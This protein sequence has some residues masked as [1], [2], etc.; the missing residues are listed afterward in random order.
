M[1]DLHIHMFPGRK[2]SPGE[3]LDKTRSAGVTGGA[4]MSMYPETFGKEDED[5]RWEARVDA[6]LDFCSQAPGFRPMFWVDPTEEDVVCKL[7][8]FRTIVAE[9]DL[10][11]RVCEYASVVL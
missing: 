5:Q 7:Y 4:V 10:V 1:Q 3:F 6:I 2:D 9:E 8:P 11:L